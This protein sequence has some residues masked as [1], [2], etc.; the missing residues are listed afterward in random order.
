MSALANTSST[1]QFKHTLT[2]NKPLSAMVSD[3]SVTT[4][5]DY[6]LRFTKQAVLVVANAAEQ[7]SQL[8]SQFLVS[9]SNSQA[10]ENTKQINVA[11]VSASTKLND[12][13]IR[14]RL[15]EQLFVNTL[16]DPE[17]SLA[18]SILKFAKQHGEAI[19]I[20]VDHAQALSLQVNYELSQLVSLAKKQKLTINVVLFGLIESAQKLT[21]NKSLFKNKMVIIDA[22]TG[23]VLSFEDKKIQLE[24]SQPALTLWQKGGLCV[25]LLVLLAILVWG[26]QLL[27]EEFNKQS[28][29]SNS[30]PVTIGGNDM[31]LQSVSSP[32]QTVRLMKK[33]EKNTD[34]NSFIDTNSMSDAT[35][36]EINKAIL[37]LPIANQYKQVAAKANDVLKALSLVNDYDE[38][39]AADSS[40]HDNSYS[41]ADN[42]SNA[43]KV[44]VNK[45]DIELVNKAEI[46]SNYYQNQAVVHEQGYVIQIAGFTD[47]NLWQRFIKQHGPENLYSYQKLLADKG[48]IVV[49][50]KVYSNKTRARAA[51]KS[52]PASLGVRKPWLKDISSVINEINTFKG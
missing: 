17:Q 35:S 5:I 20:V 13:Q 7:Y 27:S 12:I 25:V 2:G 14:C 45:R 9:L 41:Q 6:N 26:Y 1:N 39:Q 21:S 40:S 32:E 29:K 34:I 23:Q 10:E 22:S 33:K 18:V 36:E 11:F 44:I 46:N 38:L 48:F 31:V 4:R 52:L 8:A 19:S 42:E 16:F 51:I 43:D 3:I 15:I 47:N 28:T 37:A 49:T 24:K 50:S 30:L